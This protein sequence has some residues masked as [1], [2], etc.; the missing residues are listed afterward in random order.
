MHALTIKI[1]AI[2]YINKHNFPIKIKKYKLYHYNT[3]K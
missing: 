2:Y 3:Y 1:I